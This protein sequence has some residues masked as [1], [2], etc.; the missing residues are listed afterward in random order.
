MSKFKVYDSLGNYLR[1]F[2]T[3]SQAV[4][5]KIMCGRYDWTIK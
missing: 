4:T 5:Y 2:S 3:Y 1:G